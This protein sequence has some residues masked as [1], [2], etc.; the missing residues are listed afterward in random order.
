MDPK[1]QAAIEKST[2]LSDELRQRLQ[3]EDEQLTPDQVA[4]IIQLIETAETQKTE[5]ETDLEA[6]KQAL[7]QKYTEE[8]KRIAKEAPQKVMEAAE[9]ADHAAEEAELDGLLQKLDNA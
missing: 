2:L 1:L 7:F 5:V 3:K 9:Q 4:R 6:K 8:M